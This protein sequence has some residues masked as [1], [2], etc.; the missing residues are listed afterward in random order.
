MFIGLCGAAL[1]YDDAA[2]TPAIG[3][4]SSGRAERRITSTGSLYADLGHFD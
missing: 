1:V 2:I 4:L 3:N